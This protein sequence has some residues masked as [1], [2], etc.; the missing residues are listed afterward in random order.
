MRGLFSADPVRPSRCESID[1]LA[2]DP[3]EFILYRAGCLAYRRERIG[4]EETA[5][6]TSVSTRMNDNVSGL[7]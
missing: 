4:R 6:A 2:G 3:Q 5:G 7:I 1:A